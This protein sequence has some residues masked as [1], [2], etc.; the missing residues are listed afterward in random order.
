[1]R[2][3]DVRER[4]R[5]FLRD[6]V[7]HV[8]VPASMGIGLALVGCG[9]TSLSL[10]PDASA[11][12]P[13]TQPGPGGSSSVTATSSNIGPV[14]VYAAQM[15]DTGAAANTGTGPSFG[16]GSNTGTMPSS[17]TGPSMGTG[18]RTMT[19]P[20]TGT[21]TVTGPSTGTATG[22]T[23][24]ATEIRTA[25]PVYMAVMPDAGEVDAS[26]VGPTDAVTTTGRGT[27]T[28]VYTV[29][30][31]SAP[32]TAT[33]TATATGSAPDAGVDGSATL[34]GRGTNVNTFGTFTGLYHAVMPEADAPV[35]GGEAVYSGDAPKAGTP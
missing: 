34:T 19:G 18:T 8:V 26:R 30:L 11:D 22:M 14:P 27:S 2:E 28:A 13:A 29:A 32:M 3:K 10:E 31:Y 9:D 6:T 23:A 1:M 16:T 15:T 21:G 17:G 33:N 5:T 12:T 24:T 20:Q 7:R 35:A 4:I 25:T